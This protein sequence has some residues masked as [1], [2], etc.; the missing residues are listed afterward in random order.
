M[1]ESGMFSKPSAV[2][3]HETLEEGGVA[4]LD[5]HLLGA[6]KPL[7]AQLLRRPPFANDVKGDS[8]G[9][10]IVSVQAAQPVDEHLI[11][12]LAIAEHGEA[13][14][15]RTAELRQIIPSRQRK[16]SELASQPLWIRGEFVQFRTPKRRS[17]L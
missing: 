12:E 7:A 3:V 11:D 14:V 15:D 13:V 2:G 10:A 9:N 1:D 4:T 6:T 5:R 16:L 17:A 8:V